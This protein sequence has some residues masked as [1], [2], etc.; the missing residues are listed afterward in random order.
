MTVRTAWLINDTMTGEDIRLAETSAYAH[1]TAVRT[2]SGVVPAPSNPLLA[3]IGSGMTV[4]VNAGQIVIGGA[5]AGAQGQYV[6]TND[7]TLAVTI[8]NGDAAQPRT[9]VIVAYVRDTTY[10]DTTQLGGIGVVQGTPGVSF[11]VPTYSGTTALGTAVALATIK[12]P[13]NASVGGGGLTSAG[14]ILSDTRPFTAGAGG[15]IPVYSANLPSLPVFASAAYWTIDTGQLWIADG[16]YLKRVSPRVKYTATGGTQGYGTI[17]AVTNNYYLITVVQV[18]AQ[19]F[20][21][22]VEVTGSLVCNVNATADLYVNIRSGA[23]NAFASYVATASPVG[24][25]RDREFLATAGG[26]GKP[27]AYI[28]SDASGSGMDI[29]LMVMRSAGTGT[30]A[31]TGTTELNRIDAVVE[32]R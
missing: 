22:R 17:G 20:P 15:V 14:A 13:A 23:T 12:V 11:P 29:A 3:A 31:V 30:V 8:A 5:R 10:G 26:T 21:Y 32:P 19:G 2:R 27:A 24:T 1:D 4:N 28:D 9:D 16:T 18:P 7:S 25:S 6:I